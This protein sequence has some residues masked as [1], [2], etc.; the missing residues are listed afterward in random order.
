MVEDVEIIPVEIPRNIYEQH[1]MALMN[2][3]LAIDE[4]RFPSERVGKAFQTEAPSDGG[5]LPE[6]A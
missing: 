2:A 1:V 5:V 6:A 4:S 3:L